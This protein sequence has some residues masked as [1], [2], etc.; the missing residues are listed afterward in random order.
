M[1]ENAILTVG[2]AFVGEAI[3]ASLLP[4]VGEAILTS[5]LPFVVEAILNPLL[6]F[7]GETIWTSL[8]VFDGGAILIL[9]S[10]CWSKLTTMFTSAGKDEIPIKDGSRTSSG[11]R[12][13]N[14]YKII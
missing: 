12:E 3:L 2:E 10:A 13:H 11:K 14:T 8:F 6:P 7:V 1:S 5:V 4:F 9:D